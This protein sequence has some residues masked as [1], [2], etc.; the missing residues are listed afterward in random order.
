MSKIELKRCTK[1]IMPETQE[2]IVFDEKGI[3]NACKQVEIKTKVD[4]K[5]KEEELIK[6]IEQY[7]GKYS[8]D[9]IIPF[10]GGKDSSY[11]VFE[12]VKKY[13]V[14]PLLIS[15]DHGFFRP[16]VL[17]NRIKVVKKLGVD[18]LTFRSNWKVVKKLMLAS[19]KLK[20]DFCWHCHTGVFAYPMQIALKF[21]IPLIFWGEPSAEYTSYYSYEQQEE[22][23]EERFNKLVNLQMNSEDMYKLLNDDSIDKRDLEPYKYP[24]VSEL[25]SI[26]YRSVCLGSYIPWNVKVQAEIL[27]KELDWQWDI[28]EGIPETYGYQKIECML[29]GMRDYLLYIKKGFGRTAHLVSMDIRNNTMTREEGL[30]LAKEYDGRKPESM[31][32]FLDIMGITEKEFMEIALKHV[33]SPHVFKQDNVKFGKKLWDRD[34]WDKTC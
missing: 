12:L 10:S 7:R 11:T 4:W 33:K 30:K 2:S 24:S 32:W 13:K 26:N 27:R 23:N 9:C 19:L 3:C 15:F 8:Y 5:K 16:K 18:I 1:C 28:V 25:K 20:G 22:V 14:K 17:E 21:N 6:L 34:Q 31:N 29:Y